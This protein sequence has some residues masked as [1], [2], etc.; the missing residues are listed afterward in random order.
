MSNRFERDK[1]LK[2]DAVLVL[3]AKYGVR[4]KDKYTVEEIKKADLPLQIHCAS[5]EKVVAI[6]DAMLLSTEE[7]QQN[8]W[9]TGY[10][11]ECGNKEE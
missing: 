2:M 4:P 5:C 10:C 11:Q 6:I 1:Y 7:Q 3:H 9:A 8:K